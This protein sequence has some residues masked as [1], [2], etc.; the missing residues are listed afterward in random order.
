MKN[1]AEKSR[2]EPAYLAGL[3]KVGSIEIKRFKYFK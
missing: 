3:G 2:F 1:A